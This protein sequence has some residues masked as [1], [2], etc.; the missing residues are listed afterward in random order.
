MRECESRVE[1]TE[2][3]SEGE[4]AERESEGESRDELSRLVASASAGGFFS[5]ERVLL[6]VSIIGK[7]N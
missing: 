5:C 7:F 4:F 6:R 3:E 1:F 2:H